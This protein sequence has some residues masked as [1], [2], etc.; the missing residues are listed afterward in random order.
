MGEKNVMDDAANAIRLPKEAGGGCGA[1]VE[2]AKGVSAIR[3]HNGATRG[4]GDAGS[5]A[6][7]LKD[8]KELG[9]VVTFVGEGPGLTQVLGVIG[10]NSEGCRA[11]PM[12]AVAR[13]KDVR[14]V[15]GWE[16]RVGG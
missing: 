12:A 5:E 1:E 4:G 11:I 16:G 2:E 6:G 10:G 14:E 7:H 8:A 13:E 15:L 9:D 3:V